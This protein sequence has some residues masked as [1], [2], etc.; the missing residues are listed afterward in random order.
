MR[1][2]VRRNSR[3]EMTTSLGSI[4]LIVDDAGLLARVTEALA[5]KG[6]DIVFADS[7]EAA[8]DYLRRGHFEATVRVSEFIFDDEGSFLL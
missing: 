2:G 7:E 6:Y 3:Q 4:V 1:E 8:T 5:R